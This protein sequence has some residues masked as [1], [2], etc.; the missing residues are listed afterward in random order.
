MSEHGEKKLKNAL[1]IVKLPD[2]LRL[3]EYLTKILTAMDLSTEINNQQQK[4]VY[5]AY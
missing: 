5:H 1:R 2:G 4:G 3:V